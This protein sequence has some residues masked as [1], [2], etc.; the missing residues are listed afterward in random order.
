[1]IFN[2]IICDKCGE[3]IVGG[4]YYTVSCGIVPNSDESVIALYIDYTPTH[5]HAGCYSMNV[6]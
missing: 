4:V 1:M 2:K 3:E 6:I 5:Y